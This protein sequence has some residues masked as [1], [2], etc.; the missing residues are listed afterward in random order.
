MRGSAGKGPTRPKHSARPP[1]PKGLAP[2]GREEHTVD[3]SKCDVKALALADK[4]R[5][6]IRWADEQMPV[7]RS[8][9]ERFVREKPLKGLRLAACLHVTSETANLARTLAAGGADVVLCASNPLSTQD[10]VASSLV[11]H[12]GI[13]VY[14]IKGKDNETYY[15]HSLQSLDPGPHITID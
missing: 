1:G 8:I 5:A 4:G 14:A 7:V 15:R 12:D 11:E 6:R 2:G 3:T 10:D 9:R 13:A